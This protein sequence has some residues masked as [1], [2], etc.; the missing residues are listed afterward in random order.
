MKYDSSIISSSYSNILFCWQESLLPQ[1]STFLRFLDIY[2]VLMIRVC[3]CALCGLPDQVC[4]KQTDTRVFLSRH[5]GITY[6]AW[7]VHGY[8]PHS[9]VRLSVRRCTI[10]Q[11]TN[12]IISPSVK[13]SLFFPGVTVAHTHTSPLGRINAS[14]IE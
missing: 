9:Y 2:V 4:M 6:Y 14:G 1:A 13:P 7:S 8:F 11:Y 5:R 10:E 12:N 3:V